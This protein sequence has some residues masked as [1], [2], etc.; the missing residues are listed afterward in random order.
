[1]NN[2]VIKRLS[3]TRAGVAVN[4]GIIASQTGNYVFEVYQFGSVKTV[5]VAVTAGNVLILHNTFNE[6]ATV[7]FRI[8]LPTQGTDTGYVTTPA[9]EVMFQFTNIPV[10]S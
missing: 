9:G 1:M 7:L 4:T 2:L 3:D 6:S 10:F 8:K 5:T